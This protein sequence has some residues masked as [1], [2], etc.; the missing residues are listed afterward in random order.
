MVSRW[1]KVVFLFFSNH[2]MES[3]LQGVLEDARVKEPE[4]FPD[5]DEMVW[6]NRLTTWHG[7]PQ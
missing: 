5:W 1:F 7:R 6:L 4:V 3:E 2:G